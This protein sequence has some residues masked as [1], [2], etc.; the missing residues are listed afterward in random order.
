MNWP[1]AFPIASF[2]GSFKSRKSGG[3]RGNHRRR[4]LGR[5]RWHSGYLCCRCRNGRHNLR[6]RTLSKIEK[7]CDPGCCS[8]AE[9]FSG[10]IRRFC[11]TA[12]DPGHRCRI[13]P[14]HWIPQSM[15]K[16]CPLK[17]KMHS[18]QG[19]EVARAERRTRWNFL[20][21]GSLGGNYACKA[22]GK[23]RKDNCCYPTRQR[24]ALPVYTDVFIKATLYKCQT[25]KM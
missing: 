12:P 10:S 24:R 8:R 1:Q 19:R 14:E 20:G 2:R 3:T 23:R 5:H 21:C 4:D 16:Y 15:T 6:C 7:F 13:V 22:S 25:K 9:N 18:G 17:M 11:R